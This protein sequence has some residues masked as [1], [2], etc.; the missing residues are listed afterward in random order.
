MDRY[1]R[2]RHRDSGNGGTGRFRGADEGALYRFHFGRRH[3]TQV[4]LWKLRM[5]ADRGI[6]LPP[7]TV[8]E[9]AA[10]P[11]RDEAVIDKDLYSE[12]LAPASSRPMSSSWRP[13]RMLCLP[14]G[15][16]LR[17]GHSD[18]VG[19]YARIPLP[20]PARWDRRS[21]RPATSWKQLASA[22]ARRG[23]DHDHHGG[24]RYRMGG[25]RQGHSQQWPPLG[26]K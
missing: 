21:M 5:I 2:S 19:S 3:R 26:G 12:L 24:D 18:P 13:T 22:R 17:R 25:L 1:R 15:A 8:S 9:D 7:S 20:G 4:G 23:G 11:T 6:E 10:S 14:I 16:N